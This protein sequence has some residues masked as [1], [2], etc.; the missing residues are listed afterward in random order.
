MKK[1]FFLVVALMAVGFVHANGTSPESPVGMSVIKSGDVVKLFYRG[2]K[3]GKVKVTIYNDDGQKVFV[4]VMRNIEEFMRPYNFSSLPE[5]NY[6][7]EIADSQGTRSQSVKHSLY[8]PEEKTFAHLTRLG[9]EPRYMLAVPNAGS[10]VLTVRIFDGRD[11]LLYQGTEV[12]DG[13][14]AKVYNLDKIGGSHTFEII[15][16]EGNINRL[17]K[18]LNK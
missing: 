14:F 6:T 11:N 2:E 1:I 5:G 17:S 3:S 9:A 10:D 13:T 8:V 15:D 16:R 12:V 7:I 18:P 4:E